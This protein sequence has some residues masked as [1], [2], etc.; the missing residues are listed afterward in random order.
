MNF[1]N[2]LLKTENLR[3]REIKVTGTWAK[4][5]PAVEETDEGAVGHMCGSGSKAHPGALLHFFFL[6]K[7][8]LLQH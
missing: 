5:S 2:S 1:Y 3:T 7:R 8:I 4:S 6:K